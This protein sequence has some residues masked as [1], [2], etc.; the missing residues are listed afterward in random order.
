MG[1]SGPGLEP[2]NIGLCDLGEGHPAA[3]QFVLV[4]WFKTAQ[5]L[6][7]LKP[8]ALRWSGLGESDRGQPVWSTG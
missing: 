3:V 8:S 5:V 2:I 6:V 1:V 7:L 4:Q